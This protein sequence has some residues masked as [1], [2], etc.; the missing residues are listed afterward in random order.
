M[1]LRQGSE[2]AAFVQGV[3]NNMVITT[4]E[5]D[6]RCAVSRSI[7]VYYYAEERSVTSALD[8]R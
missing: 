7:V 4:S 1:A 3:R 8:L 2:L 5:S 6:N